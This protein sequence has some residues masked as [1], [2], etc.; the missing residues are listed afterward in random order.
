[1][2]SCGV[3]QVGLN[4]RQVYAGSIQREG[5]AFVVSVNDRVPRA[6]AVVPA[7]WFSQ[8]FQNAGVLTAD[9][10]RPVTRWV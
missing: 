9:T 5:D 8:D 10:I 2:A 3:P 6:T 7:L 4:K 1:M